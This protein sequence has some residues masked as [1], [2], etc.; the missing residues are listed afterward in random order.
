MTPWTFERVTGEFG[1]DVLRR[2]VSEINDL[3]CGFAGHGVPVNRLGVPA[4]VWAR[5]MKRGGATDEGIA[6]A[7]AGKAPDRA[8][9][10]GPFNP[11]T[12]GTIHGITAEKGGPLTAGEVSDLIERSLRAKEL[13]K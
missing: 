8:E 2:I 5:L 7:M 1:E 12:I 9:I 6:R 3:M 13:L 10:R 4:D 11:W